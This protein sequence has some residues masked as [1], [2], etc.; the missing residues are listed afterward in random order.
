MATEN[1]LKKKAQDLLKKGKDLIT[2]KK[3]THH[4]IDKIK[5]R[6]QVAPDKFV[7]KCPRCKVS[8]DKKVYLNGSKKYPIRNTGTAPYP[9]FTIKRYV[10][11]M[12]G[13][14]WKDRVVKPKKK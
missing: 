11:R 14:M 12:C 4:S 13:R 10:C 6:K 1:P 2:P 9:K 5:S 3:Q 7:P 8:N